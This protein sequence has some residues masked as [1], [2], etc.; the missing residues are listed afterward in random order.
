MYDAADQEKSF[1]TKYS[2]AQ[3]IRMEISCRYI[4]E[5][6]LTQPRYFAIQDLPNH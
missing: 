2:A 4:S 6:Y 5:K 3:N 1:T